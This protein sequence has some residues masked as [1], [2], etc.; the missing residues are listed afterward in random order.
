MG[1]TGGRHRPPG[2]PAQGSAPRGSLASARAGEAGGWGPGLAV[3][4]DPGKP[5]TA[6]PGCRGGGLGPLALPLRTPPC[7]QRPAGSI[8]SRAVLNVRCSNRS[9]SAIRI[10]PQI[11]CL[12]LS[13]AEQGWPRDPRLN[14]N[15]RKSGGTSARDFQHITVQDFGVVL[16]LRAPARL[17]LGQSGCSRRA[18][19]GRTTPHA[20]RPL[21]EA[22]FP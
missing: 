2:R 7:G 9:V 1:A 8:A 3:P 10:L 16:S 12:W 4:P 14:T 15:P 22:A 21:P 5:S 13:R 6:L 20:P 11:R 19:A 17:P 18:G